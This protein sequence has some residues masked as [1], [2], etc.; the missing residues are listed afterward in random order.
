MARVSMNNN[1]TVA[2]ATGPRYSRSFV[3]YEVPFR[4]DDP[5]K[6]A[7]TEGLRSFY[8][9]YHDPTGR[10]VRFD[11]VQL[12]RAEK[13]PRE[14]ELPVAEPPG[15]TIYFEAVRGPLPGEFAGEKKIDY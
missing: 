3:S 9:A 12:V 4:P 10:V 14:L 13:A 7:D 11:K 15:A 2:E 5:V 6:F 8:A 1:V